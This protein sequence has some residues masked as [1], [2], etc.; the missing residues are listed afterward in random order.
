[1]AGHQNMAD[2][3]KLADLLSHINDLAYELQGVADRKKAKPSIKETKDPFT[4]EVTGTTERMA[5]DFSASVMV[6]F[7]A[8][9]AK[10]VDTLIQVLDET[11]TLN[12]EAKEAIQEA[13]QKLEDAYAAYLDFV[14][15]DGMDSDNV[16]GFDVEGAKKIMQQAAGSVKQ[17]PSPDNG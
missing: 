7:V 12:P 9:R 6:A 4:G 8:E 17:D 11:L 16:E 5:V 2:K 3:E 1:M 10:H 14:R 15:I 13:I